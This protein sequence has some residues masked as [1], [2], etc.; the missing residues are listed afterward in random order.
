VVVL[1]IR[2]SRFISQSIPSLVKGYCYES[3]SFR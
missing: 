1:V 3:K 2:D